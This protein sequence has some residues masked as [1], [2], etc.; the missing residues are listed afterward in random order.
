MYQLCTVV[1]AAVPVYLS[2]PNNLLK[3]RSFKSFSRIK[4]KGKEYAHPECFLCLS[5]VY[6]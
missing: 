4:E 2:F 3:L 5:F 1:A 6:H